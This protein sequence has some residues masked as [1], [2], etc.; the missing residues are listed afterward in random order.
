MGLNVIVSTSTTVCTFGNASGC[1]APGLESTMCM[2]AAVGPRECELT[3]GDERIAAHEPASRFAAH[4][5]AHVHAL[6]HRIQRPD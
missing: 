1:A 4:R 2:L 6:A 5:V 3:L